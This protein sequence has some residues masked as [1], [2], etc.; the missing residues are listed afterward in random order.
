MQ[1]VLPYSNVVQVVSNMKKFILG[2]IIVLLCAAPCFGQVGS[3]TF[4]SSNTDF[5]VVTAEP[6]TGYPCTMCVWEYSDG[7]TGV[8]TLLAQGDNTSMSKYVDIVRLNSETISCT[9]NTTLDGHNLINNTPFSDATW[10]HYCCVFAAA[11]DWTVYIDGVADGT[12]SPNIA[13]ATGGHNLTAVGRLP[14]SS[15]TNYQDGSIAYAGIWTRAL[16]IEEVNIVYQCSPGALPTGLAGYWPLTDTGD[17]FFD[18]SINS[19]NMA[20]D[21]AETST[22]GP[23]ITQCGGRRR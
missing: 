18:M 23:P 16:T 20:N 1:V 19:N 3:R 17:T 2:L 9:L 13:W 8:G 7:Q 10:H 11:A 15:P 22:D 21:G 5:G 6:C 14:R 12:A 4:V